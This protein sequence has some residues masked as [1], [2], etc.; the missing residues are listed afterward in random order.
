MGILNKSD[1]RAQDE[2]SAWRIDHWNGVERI[3]LIQEGRVLISHDLKA[4]WLQVDEP[5]VL[6]NHD[7]DKR[8]PFI[9]LVDD[10]P[11]PVRLPWDLNVN[12]TFSY[13]SQENISLMKSGGLDFFNPYRFLK[14][15]SWVVG[16]VTLLFILVTLGIV[17]PA[18]YDNVYEMLTD[19]PV[20]EEQPAP[21]TES[22]PLPEG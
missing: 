6:Y 13:Y 17:G 9:M 22:T 8:K 5:P 16:G 12:A 3:N 7:P 4:L 15:F 21:G 14:I 11:S 19:K 20:A 1:P 2:A 18:A 10:L